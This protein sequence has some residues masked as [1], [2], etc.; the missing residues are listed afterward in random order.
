MWGKNKKKTETDLTEGSIVRGLAAFV[1]PLFL[2]QLLQQLYNM[3]DAWVVG[4]FADNDAF[5]A[6]SLS[7]NMTFLIIGFFNGI[8]LGGGVVISRYYGQKNKWKTRRAIHTNFMFG[9]AASVLSTIVGLLLVPQIL[10]WLKTP[11]SVMPDA[12]CISE[13][14]SPV[15]PRSLCIISAWPSCARWATAFTRSII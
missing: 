6:V 8:A 10:H 15:C 12:W 2:G 1:W 7:A 3:A 4:N 9:I 5:A 11:E 14:I 13:F